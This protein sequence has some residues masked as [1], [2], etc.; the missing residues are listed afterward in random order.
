MRNLIPSSK[1]VRAMGSQLIYWPQETL[2]D[3]HFVQKHV[4]AIKKLS[5]TDLNLKSIA[6]ISSYAANNKLTP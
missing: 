2:L 6:L 1:R 3:S 4:K 5:F